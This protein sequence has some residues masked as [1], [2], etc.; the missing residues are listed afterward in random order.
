MATRRGIRQRLIQECQL[1]YNSTVT[2]GGGTT[3]IDDTARLQNTAAD[4]RSWL[5]F[6]M[7]R[8]S[9]AAVEQVRTASSYTVASGRLNHGGVAYSA[10]PTAAEVYEVFKWVHPDDLNTAI[11]RAIERLWY[12]TWAPLTLVTDGDMEA[13]GVTDWAVTNATRAKVTTTGYRQDQALEVT[14]TSANGYAQSASIAVKSGAYGYCSVIV[15]ATGA[16]TA[17]LIVWD[18][19]NSVAI[20]TGTVAQ[21]MRHIASISFTVPATCKQIALRLGATGASDV[22]TWDNAIVHVQHANQFSA[23]SWVT[24][25][26]QILSLRHQVMLGAPVSLSSAQSFYPEDAVDW[27]P[28]KYN[29][30]EFDL[31]GTVPVRLVL[32]NYAGVFP[33]WI[34]A[35]RS[36]SA[37]TADT[38]TGGTVDADE[39]LV[40]AAAKV[41]VY[42]ILNN[43]FK[44]KFA[45]QLENSRRQFASRSKSDTSRYPK[46][47]TPVL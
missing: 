28:V 7:Y 11:N 10:T 6:Y 35:L 29:A 12:E 5:G 15:S 17:Q 42:E 18:V 21:I 4:S 13:S 25:K 47:W 8:P 9:A 45:K 1:G 14:N 16:A 27:P 19:T 33:L 26:A 40:V 43:R 31:T 34:Q 37:F 22:T 32:D 36:Y 38:S 46:I 2:A 20:Y 39:D 44:D 30:I 23:P 3:Y 24:K 41:E